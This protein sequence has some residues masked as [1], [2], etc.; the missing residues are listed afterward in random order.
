MENKNFS[1]KCCILAFC[2]VVLGPAVLLEL[3]IVDRAY[4]ASYYAYHISLSASDFSSE[5][6]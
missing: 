1:V 2:I 3:L 4:V 6:P 5:M